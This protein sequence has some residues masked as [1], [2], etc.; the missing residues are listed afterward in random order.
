MCTRFQDH[1]RE[2]KSSGHSCCDGFLPELCTM[3]KEHGMSK[4]EDG[5][6][7]SGGGWL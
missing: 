4:V 5:V 3:R 6:S 1:Q 7:G 2:G